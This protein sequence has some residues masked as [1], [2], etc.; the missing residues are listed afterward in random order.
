MELIE[1]HRDV[2]KLMPYLHL[3]VQSGSDKILKM[4][5]RKH[6]AKEYIKVIE[7][8]RDYNPHIAISGDFIIGF[9][10]ETD[11][12]HQATLDLIRE[13]NY[14]QAYSFKYSSRPGTPAAIFLDHL[15]E[16]VKSARLQ[17]VQELLRLQQMR[18]NKKSI[19][20]TLKP[21]SSATTERVSESNL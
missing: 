3:P 8:I 21:N 17:E 1:A 19:N 18:F 15:N 4:M 6:S 13:I 20:S 14:S 16:N 12:D 11:K 5:N 7:K 10:G 9:P 2:S